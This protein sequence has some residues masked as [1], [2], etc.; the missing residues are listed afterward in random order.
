MESLSLYKP[1]CS[2][3][4]CSLNLANFFFHM[5]RLQ[6]CPWAELSTYSTASVVGQ[7]S[8]T[9]LC[10]PWRL[11]LPSTASPRM[12]M[13]NTKLYSCPCSIWIPSASY[14][15]WSYIILSSEEA[16]V[17]QIQGFLVLT[18]TQEIPAT[19]LQISNVLRFM[20][21]LLTLVPAEISGK[22]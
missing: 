22:K 4:P 13:T 21:E 11:T 10:W 19:Q 15:L 7:L 16:T 12:N 3:P 1:I 18:T 14:I 6:F 17:A 9:P 5:K 8:N 20:A 2:I